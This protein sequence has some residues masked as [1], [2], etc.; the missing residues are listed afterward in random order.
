MGTKQKKKKI[1]III[2]KKKKKKND[3][4]EEIFKVQFTSN[5]VAVFIRWHPW[6]SR[7]WEQSK[8]P[9]QGFDL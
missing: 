3:Q 6:L 9:C 8:E 1:I 2:K 7:Q 4:S 5:P